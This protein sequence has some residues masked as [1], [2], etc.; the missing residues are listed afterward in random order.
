MIKNSITATCILTLPIVKFTSVKFC[1]A[2]NV[3]MCLASSFIQA[4][5]E[6]SGSLVT[7]R[8][9]LDML[10]FKP[11][12][13]LEINLQHPLFCGSYRKLCSL[14]RDARKIPSQ[15][16]DNIMNLGLVCNVDI[17]SSHFEAVAKTRYKKK[18]GKGLIP[19]HIK[20]WITE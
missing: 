9:P 11:L 10:K 5:D 13:N 12:S 2:V 17:A 3:P 7:F 18:S 4:G 16:T 14:H 1:V 20:H 8:P 19:S 6:M 15:H